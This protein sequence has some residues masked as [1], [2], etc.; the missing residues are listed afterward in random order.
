MSTVTSSDFLPKLNLIRA[1]PTAKQRLMLRTIS[2]ITDGKVIVYD[3]TTPWSYLMECAATLAANA[4][5]RNETLDSRRYPDN[6]NRPE[7]I[8]LH[9]S[10]TDYLDRFATPSRATFTMFLSVDEIALKAV[11][12]GDGSGV[13]LLTIP[14]HSE[15][16][17][18]GLFFT[19][20]YATEIRIFPNGG[21]TVL[22]NTDETS[23]VLTLPTNQVDWS[24]DS[25]RLNSMFIRLELPLQQMSIN[26]QMLS[27]NAVTGFSRAYS[28]NDQFFYCRAYTK[29]DND[30]TWTEI[31]TT[32]TDQV[33]DVRYPTA[34]LKVLDGILQVQIPQIYFTNG[35]IKDSLRLD[36]YTTKGAIEQNLS[37]ID[38]RAY[39]ARWLDRDTNSLSAFSAPMASLTQIQ[40]FCEGS[41]TGGS[42]GLSM[43]A[44]RER[45]ITRTLSKD[46]IPL[47]PPQLLNQLTDAGYE[48]VLSLDNLT[49]RQYLATRS[50][51]NPVVT[52]DTSTDTLTASTAMG[53]T[54]QTFQSTLVKLVQQSSVTNNGDRV[55]ITPDAVFVNEDGIIRI[56]TNTEQTALLNLVNDA[57][58]ALVNLV[59]AK[60]YLF[61]PF[62][63]VLDISDNSFEARAYRLDDPSIVS[64]YFKAANN[65]L[66]IDVSS[67]AY[68]VIL[69]NDK[70][71]YRLLVELAVSDAFK[72]LEM[73]RIG[74]QLSYIP[75]YLSQRVFVNGSLVTPI[76]SDTGRP[77]D[78]R[79]VYEFIIPT[80]FDVD[81]D[82]YLIHE[83]YQTPLALTTEFDLVYFVR[84]H[85][86][87]GATVSEIDSLIDASKL[88]NYLPGSVYKGLSWEKMKIRFGDRLDKLWC[89]T[90]SVIDSLE[91]QT[92]STDIPAVYANNVY[93]RDATGNVI[94]HYNSGT[95]DLEFT[96]L[97]NAGDPVLLEGEPVYAH[98]AGDYVLDAEGNPIPVGG[99]R[100]MLRQTDIL[101]LDGKYYFATNQTTQ[102]YKTGVV[103]LLSEWILNDLDAYA[104][105][106]LEQTELF[107][108]PK[109]S[110]GSVDVYTNDQQLVR[111]KAEQTFNV[112]CFVD[113]TVFENKAIRR[114]IERTIADTL[115]QLLKVSTISVT[116]LITGLREA[117]KT[118]V[119]SFQLTGFTNDQ[120]SI[121][122]LKDASI[123][124][125]VGK[126]L[127]VLSNRTLAV[128]DSINV[129]YIIHR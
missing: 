43:E 116:D 76:D 119:I 88:D 71:G 57:P 122:T 33:Y 79:Y 34:I 70:R 64:K 22:Y 124:P 6:A 37:N 107:F 28:F 20:Q 126:R 82:D 45:V 12:I 25:L 80:N 41:A 110:V 104:D 120:Y 40:I 87:P 19:A 73:E 32:H 68:T 112:I 56:L 75:D 86:P 5:L 30:N 2:D 18:A 67:K 118:D 54:M 95:Q 52:T 81:R 15:F 99:L 21:I 38:S 51:P 105:R 13:K 115:S 83:P 102:D 7:D 27:L 123:R 61:T 10:D 50:L 93:E 96:I 39:L 26:T 53:C 63:Y 24:L 59:N 72:E 36:I 114:T 23:P 128:Q 101:F 127:V 3:P 108:H 69:T 78:E 77:A 91:Y 89:R 8:Y 29:D 44:L 58:E 62:Y 129:S 14:K 60:D 92:Y 1:D 66:L 117:L 16:I 121:V 31:R 48:L 17:V 94:Q 109:K 97:H 55:T 85:L 35:L 9:M 47:S 11:D 65:S 100:G 4:I 49:D 113:K 74:I 125:S 90:R 111:I 103:D 42:N 84:D 106:L 46:A 98:R